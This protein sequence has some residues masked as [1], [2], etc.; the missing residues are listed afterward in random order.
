MGMAGG[1]LFFDN[2]FVFK[3]IEQLAA[4]WLSPQPFWPNLFARLS[5]CAQRARGTGRR[6]VLRTDDTGEQCRPIE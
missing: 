6:I 4:E 3:G 1:Q 2:E 5:A